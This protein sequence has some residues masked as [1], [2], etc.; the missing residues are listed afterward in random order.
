[1]ARLRSK[2][3]LGLL[4]A[5]LMHTKAFLVN[6]NPGTPTLA[7]PDSS[8]DS[9]R[10]VFQSAAK[11]R[12][13]SSRLQVALATPFLSWSNDTSIG[14]NEEKLFPV[15]PRYRTKQQLLLRRIKEPIIKDQ[16]HQQD[17]PLACQVYCDLD[18]V[19]VDFEHGIRQIFPSIHKGIQI[20]DIHR[21]TMW[22]RVASTGSFFESL[23]WTREGKQLWN[24]IQPL[25]PDILTG[26][27]TSYH[28]A[29]AQ[30][31]RWCQRELK[32][33]VSHVDMAGHMWMHASVNGGKRVSKEAGFVSGDDLLND[34]TMMNVITC[35][36]HNKHHESGPGRVL[37]DD[38]KKLGDAWIEKGGIFIHH[39][40]D[41]EQTIDQL[42]Q[43]GILKE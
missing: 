41:A 34:Q 26:V 24:A 1:M 14:T 4:A 13:L 40:G 6:Q 2:V 20:N 17:R 29:R 5:S 22:Q 21:P 43:Y 35:W 32:G 36:S 11:S 15:H 31:V 8:N 7:Y 18:G 3:K 30:K 39:Q 25:Q 28:D 37:I 12:P 9:P 42:Y 10:L 19:L 38:C 16:Q 33:S 27:P 23:P